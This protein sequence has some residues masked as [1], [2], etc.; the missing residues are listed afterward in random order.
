MTAPLS[1]THTVNARGDE[2]SLVRA[3]QRI[4]MQVADEPAGHRRR[5]AAAA[6]PVSV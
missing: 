5:G 6:A 2:N 3:P 4:Q 1:V